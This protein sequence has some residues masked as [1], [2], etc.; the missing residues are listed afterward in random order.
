MWRS[1]TSP[2]THPV[3]Q[4]QQEAWQD[5]HWVCLLPL[6]VRLHEAAQHRDE[7][8]GQPYQESQ[9]RHFSKLLCCLWQVIFQTLISLFCRCWR[10]MT[11]MWLL[12]S[13]FLATGS[14]RAVMTT[15]LRSV[16]L[17]IMNLF[18]ISFANIRRT[19]VCFRFGPRWRVNAFAHWLVTQVKKLKDLLIWN[20]QLFL[21]P[22]KWY[23]NSNVIIIRG[24]LEQ[25]DG[26]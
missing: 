14:C 21:L 10:A 11:T 23:S 18:W 26:K 22:Q 6:E 12:A 17:V 3:T 2:T 8:E 16:H 20:M 25:S 19:P 1:A 13:S 7:L 24:C 5:H 9:G 15:L 4:G